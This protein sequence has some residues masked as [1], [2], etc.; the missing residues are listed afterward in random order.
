MNIK[1][2]RTATYLYYICSVGT[3]FWHTVSYATFCLNPIFKIDLC[4]RRRRNILHFS[5]NVQ[6]AYLGGWIIDTP[7]LTYLIGNSDIF[8]F[9]VSW[10]SLPE[11]LLCNV[12]V[13]DRVSSRKKKKGSEVLTHTVFT[14]SSLFLILLFDFTSKQTHWVCTRLARQK[15]KIGYKGA[16]RILRLKAVL[17]LKTE[18]KDF[19][20]VIDLVAIYWV[21]LRSPSVGTLFND[22]LE[23]Y[24]SSLFWHTPVVSIEV[25]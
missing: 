7:E 23:S 11:T 14:G 22:V 21:P 16:R 15:T 6:S 8:P 25:L 18:I 2:S 5:F 1:F 17:N 12:R 13:L 24:K 19:L 9:L 10:V 4:R 20:N 3:Y